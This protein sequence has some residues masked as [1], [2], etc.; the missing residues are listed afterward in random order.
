MKQ[1]DLIEVAGAEERGSGGVQGEA[2]RD[3]HAGQAKP[4]HWLDECDHEDCTYGGRGSVQQRERS[5]REG[6]SGLAIPR[7]R[8]T[9]E[10]QGDPE[11]GEVRSDVVGG[12]SQYIEAGEEERA[13]D[14]AACRES[15]LLC[16]RNQESCEENGPTAQ[17]S[18]GK[19]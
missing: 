13:G 17:E 1:V 16:P 19:Q 9:F 18:G 4:A 3:P 11:C 12:D 8:E 10:A 6:Q 2:D 14:D 5:E 15:P 7:A